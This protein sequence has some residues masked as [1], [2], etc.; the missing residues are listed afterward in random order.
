MAI[1]YFIW[2]D[3]DSRSMHLRCNRIPIIRPEE[4]VQH[5][6]IPGRPGELT[7]TEGANIYN[8]YIQT[9]SISVDGAEYVSPAETWLSGDGYVTFH[10]Q[11]TLKQKARI[12]NAVTFE[13]HSRNVDSWHADVQF[14]CEPYK[15]LTSETPVTVTESGSTITNDSAFEALPKLTIVGSGNITITMGGHVLTLP[16]VED[17]CVVDSEMEWVTVNG[18]P[19]ANAWSGE[20]PTISTG[21]NTILFTGNVTSIEIEQRYRYL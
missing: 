17:G 21:E 5:V 13:R 18:I 8:S 1:P 16:G 19:Q 11:P 6:T 3:T 10:A 14:Y 2:N 9:A 12:I 15:R 20:F 7:Q 4:R